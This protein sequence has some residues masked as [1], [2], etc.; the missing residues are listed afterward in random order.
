MLTLCSL[1]HEAEAVV[2]D[3]VAS[4][5]KDCTV[6]AVM[7]RLTHVTAYDQIALMDAGSLVEFGEADEMIS[8]DTRFAKLYRAQMNEKRDVS[9]GSPNAGQDNRKR[10]DLS[11]PGKP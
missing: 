7:H 11:V 5:F 6:L 3:I 8:G 4:D 9:D 10:E 2:Q 1:D